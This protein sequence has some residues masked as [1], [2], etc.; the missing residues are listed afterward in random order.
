MYVVGMYVFLSS[1]K[2][3]DFENILRPLAEN[4][5]SFIYIQMYIE[6]HLFTYKYTYVHAI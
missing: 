2:L 6:V 5:P 3:F 1:F 4:V